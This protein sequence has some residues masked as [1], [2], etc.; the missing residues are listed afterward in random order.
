M[1]TFSVVASSTAEV[2][3]ALR[4]YLE[5]T[6]H[7]DFASFPT[8][9]E[10]LHKWQVIGSVFVDFIPLR[11]QICLETYVDEVRVSVNPLSRND[12]IKFNFIFRQI[13]RFLQEYGLQIPTGVRTACFQTQ[14]L[15]DDFALSDDEGPTW[16]ERV[17]SVL[18]DT[19][20]SRTE[21]REE[22]FRTIAQWTT[23]TPASHEALAQGLVNR[24]NELS[25][26]FCTHAQASVAETYPFAVAM[27]TLS[28]ECSATTRRKLLQS[29]LSSILD[30]ASKAIFPNVI[31]NEYQ[32]A[33][34]ALGMD[35]II[36][37]T[38]QCVTKMSST[39]N[40]PGEE[41]EDDDPD[42]TWSQHCIVS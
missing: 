10:K 25:S 7:S 42:C 23:S 19:N 1:S 9:A 35:E 28:E 34:R 26:L 11:V 33:M 31:A 22:A 4:A 39:G 2:A 27:R 29:R 16:Q 6:L 15:D 12:T 20:S 37:R 36:I 21:V 40:V 13:V 18:R 8:D 14:L 3:K 5:E 32:I 24:A 17:E 30:A 41:R 38:G